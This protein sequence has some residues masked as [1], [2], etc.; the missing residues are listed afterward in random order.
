MG[1]DG[2]RE[3]GRWGGEEGYLEFLEE[4]GFMDMRKGEN[5]G[6]ER[7]VLFPVSFEQFDIHFFSMRGKAGGRKLT[8]ERKKTSST[9]SARGEQKTN[10]DTLNDLP[11]TFPKPLTV[12][13]RDSLSILLTPL[14]H[15]GL[16]GVIT[17]S[18]GQIGIVRDIELASQMLRTQ[19]SQNDDVDVHA[20]HEDAD[21]R[22]GG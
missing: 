22:W 8:G 4:I 5:Q 14:V 6:D 19:E 1:R 2:G 9:F 10:S 7:G 20:G 15:D 17:R 12:L 18:R 3:K 16:Q 11:C 13:I 21:D